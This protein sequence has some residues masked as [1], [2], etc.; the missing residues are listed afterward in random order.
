[1]NSIWVT[2]CVSRLLSIEDIIVRYTKLLLSGWAT[3]IFASR[4]RSFC[5]ALFQT[6]SWSEV[7]ISTSR[8]FFP[9]PTCYRECDNVVE[10]LSNLPVF[11]RIVA[12]GDC[13]YFRT[14]RGRLFEGRRLFEG[15]DYF[16]FFSR[17]VVPYIFGF[18]IPS[19]KGKSEI[20]E[21]YHRK[22]L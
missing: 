2:A 15:G 12:G 6:W 13:F 19:N 7:V 17:E 22:K 9:T 10:D 20:H 21:H 1:M 11:P 4:R 14:K 5:D 8:G 3:T 18:I 16:K